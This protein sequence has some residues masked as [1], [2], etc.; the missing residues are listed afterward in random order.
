MDYAWSVAADLLLHEQDASAGLAAAAGG[1][2]I[3]TSYDA[4]WTISN[5]SRAA[6]S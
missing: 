5:T 3:W 2:I 6:W 4:P 1:Q